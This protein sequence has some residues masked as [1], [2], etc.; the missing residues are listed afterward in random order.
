MTTCI[1]ASQGCSKCATV[2][3]HTLKSSP[4]EY[5]K[6]EENDYFWLQL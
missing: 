2:L 1:K 6:L 4:K 5:S 3:L